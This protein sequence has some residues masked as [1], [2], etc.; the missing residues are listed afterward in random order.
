MQYSTVD[1]A[2]GRWREILPR[3]GIADRFLVNRHGPCPLCGGKDRFRFD[4]RDGSGSY[5]CGQCGPGPGMLLLRKLHGWDHKAACA[6]V[7]EIIGSAAPMPAAPVKDHTAGRLTKIERVLAEADDPTV[8]H[9]YLHGRGLSVVPGVLRGHRA[10]PYVDGD[11]VF[12]GRI[13]AVVAPILAPD[14]RLVSAQRIYADRTLAERK[15]TMPPAGTIK[16]GTV[17]LFDVADQMGI[18]EGVETAVAAHELFGVPTW[19]A[20]T[21]DNLA[22]F[23]PPAGV[24]RITI[25]G[26]HDASYTGHAVAYALARRL[27]LKHYDVTVEIPP[28]PG[29]DWLDVLAPSNAARAA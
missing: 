29:T 13:Q 2:R 6:A 8:V 16:G 27:A 19:A 15:K 4:D 23:D 18:A 28:E 21:A 3:L 20:L 7:D 22:V 12:V 24:R 26:D 11:G 14:G 25:F 9:R 1:R 17:R 10:L 5:F